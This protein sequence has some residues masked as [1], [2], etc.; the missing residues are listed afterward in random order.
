MSLNPAQFKIQRSVRVQEGPTLAYQAIMMSEAGN[1]Q[2]NTMQK[3]LDEQAAAEE[4]SNA[5]R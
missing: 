1:H 5:P 4:R 2:Q 3:S